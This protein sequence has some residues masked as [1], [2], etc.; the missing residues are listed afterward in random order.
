MIGNYILSGRLH[1]I[2]AV[3]FSALLSL[4]IPPFA[5]FISGSVVA[6]ITLRKGP[7]VALQTLLASLFVL[8]AFSM[9][10]N[11]PVQLSFAYAL[12]I[13]LPVWFGA[14]ALRLS[15]QQGVL[16]I[17]I[18]MLAASLIA[19]SYIT[20]GDV[21]AWW[22]Q[23]LSLMLDKTMTTEEAGEFKKLLEPAV[24]MI[25]AMMIAGF[26]LNIILSVLFGRWWQSRLF[27]EGAFQSEFYALRLPALIL[28]IS[29]VIVLLVFTLA[30]P[31]R[32]LF[33]DIMV[34]LMFMYLIQGIVAV[35][36][37]VD[38]F[39]LSIGWVVSMYCLLVL[40]PHMALLIACLGMTDIY[41]G[42]RKE[43]IPPE[44]E[45]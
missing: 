4:L 16:V 8:I 36:K 12:V 30:E 43:K 38:K 20:L 24:S 32:D 39:K 42:W 45:S 22:Q 3:T 6:L 27:N 35:H 11:L 25:N 5:F 2:A 31:W 17:A 10:A 13:W 7:A 40:V 33:R 29:S 26:M 18:G 34:I 15:E 37:N 1:A 41:I 9:L 21:S 19:A 14:V 23:W 28:P 44:N